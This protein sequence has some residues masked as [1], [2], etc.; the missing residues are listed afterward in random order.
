MPE[1]ILSPE[2][3]GAFAWLSRPR[4]VVLNILRNEYGMAGQQALDFLA[5][6]PDAALP[7]DMIPEFSGPES[8]IEVGDL[9]GMEPGWKKT[10]VDI[11]GGIGLDPITYVPGGKVIQGLAKGAGAGI[12]KVGLAPLASK[13][14]NAVADTMNW[15]SLTP[16]QK[17]AELKAKATG[18]MAQATSS[19][20]AQRIA[21]MLEPQ[22]S[23]VV[24]DAMQNV[25]IDPATKQARLLA[26]RRMTGAMWSQADNEADAI[27]SLQAHPAYQAAPAARKAAM[28]QATKD[29]VALGQTQADEFL[30]GS[31]DPAVLGKSEGPYLQRRFD[32]END[33]TSPI[34]GKPNGG[35]S[36]IN[37]RA[38]KTDDDL[39]QGLNAD[40]K[41]MEAYRRDLPASLLERAAQQGKIATRKTLGD[42]LYAPKLKPGMAPSP[43]DITNSA[44]RT[45]VVENLD[46]MIAANGPERDFAV[47]AKALFSGMGERG[48]F[49][50]LMAS[51]NRNLF[52]P[53]ATVGVIVPRVSFTVRNSLS[54]IAQ[55]L[56]T[57]G[58][59][60]AVFAD[61]KWAYQRL[62]GGIMDP[63]EEFVKITTKGKSGRITD[64][65]NEL[66]ARIEEAYAQSKGSV[67]AA[68]KYLQTSGK[69]M[70]KDALEALEQN[71]LENPIK[72]DEVMTELAPGASW[73]AKAKNNV[74]DLP[75]KLN[76]HVEDRIRA[77]LFVAS[78][79]AGQSPSAAAASVRNAVLDY[80]VP[81][82]ANRTM[83]TYI[84]FGAFLSQSLPQSGKLLTENLIEGGI[85]G[86]IA[87]GAARGA[88]TQMFETDPDNPIYP[89]MVGKM[90]VPMGTDE[91]GNPQYLTA[92]GLPI[93]GLGD[94][95]EGTDRREFERFGGV[96][97]HPL[98]KAGYSF[99][100][101]NDPYFGTPYGSYDKP[102]KVMELAGFESGPTSSLIR[103]VLGTG[104]A[105]PAVHLMNLPEPWL[106]DRQGPLLDSIRSL[107]GARVRSVDEDMALRLNLEEALRNNPQVKQYSGF[108]Q[109][110]DDPATQDLMADY[111]EAKKRIAE[112]RKAAK[113]AAAATV[114]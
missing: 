55:A 30:H 98:L 36:A 22:E 8:D 100:S 57:P 102:T 38:F 3:E 99:V 58:A 6:I 76:K 50:N 89:D 7:G 42:M 74:W 69:P 70:S 75:S 14:R 96:A 90:T 108:Y 15:H 46:K 104:V 63:L 82:T 92:L 67:Q 53:A 86:A 97:A 84:P 81:T 103:K 109:G 13:A 11:V 65:T 114:L 19:A 37:A 27:A 80:S 20:E 111:N 107:T 71:V 68:K 48:T 61:P 35:S 23:E 12:S 101:G 95:P 60:G 94:I 29:A 93:E 51:F 83:R 64:D 31:L 18:E 85:P 54:S 87:G 43:F 66:L 112:K 47:R 4:R 26:Q 17:A 106:D 9:A 72:V 49:E 73:M 110:S 113:E 25:T 59:R 16:Y 10:A 34:F 32:I 1:D 2:D 28:E 44:H 24:F 39:V 62:V 105:Q 78:K 56:S 33:I 52:K 88:A 41:L 40:P 91:N 77:G 21:K 45:N 79:K 5:N